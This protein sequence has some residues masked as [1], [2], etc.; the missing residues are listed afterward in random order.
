MSV[1]RIIVSIICHWALKN[2]LVDLGMLEDFFFSFFFFNF[3]NFY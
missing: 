2:G 3:L 1:S